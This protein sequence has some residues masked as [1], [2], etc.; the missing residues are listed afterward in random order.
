MHITTQSRAYV[1][2]YNDPSVFAEGVILLCTQWS[3]RRLHL[4]IG[5]LAHHARA[6]VQDRISK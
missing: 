4:R 1:T 2:M 3:N 6:L 5:L